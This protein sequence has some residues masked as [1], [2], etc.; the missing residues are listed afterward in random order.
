M[1]KAELQINSL[2]QEQ[3]KLL[4]AISAE[5]E[6]AALGGDDSYDEAIA[7]AGIDMIYKL[8]DLKPPKIVWCD[9]P[10]ALARDS[11]L[12]KGDTIDWLGCGYDSGWTAFYDYMQRI[13]IEYD[14]DWE[15]DAWKNFILKSGVFATVL[16][17]NVA[18]LCRRPNLVKVNASF[19]LHNPSGPAISWR[20]GY[21]EYAL[22]GVFVDKELVMTP[23]ENLDPVIL[24][25]E[26]NAE[27]RRE[28]VRKIGI[29][30]V[31]Q[32]LGAEV[33]DKQ[34]EYEL[35]LLNIGDGRKREYLKMQNPSI[36]TYHIEG[37]PV[38]T[39]TVA[40]A[41]AW[42]NGRQDAPSKLT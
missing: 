34:G 25:K 26:K 33:I 23:G 24:V 14:A 12:P 4:D 15:F 19:D 20:D 40:A 42:R 36:A 29:E 31:V 35:L 3:E 5:Y 7:R 2:T 22:N 17:E 8:S 6:G 39:K 32:K 13:G 18:Y 37:V 9:S 41:L 16:R 1:K 21:E 10:M 28:I 38:G 30:R 27:I 11:E